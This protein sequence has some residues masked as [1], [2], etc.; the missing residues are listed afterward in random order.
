MT[1]GFSTDTLNAYFCMCVCIFCVYMCVYTTDPK[2]HFYF[3]SRSQ[4][5]MILFLTHSLWSQIPSTM[6]SPCLSPIVWW[7]RE[8][9]P[10]SEW[11]LSHC[12]DVSVTH[13]SWH[14]SRWKSDLLLVMLSLS[15]TGKKGRGSKKEMKKP[16]ILLMLWAINRITG[17]NRLNRRSFKRLQSYKDGAMSYVKPSQ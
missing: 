8:Q 10:V 15:I 9:R 5:N 3:S 4:M 7:D 1:A 16:H 2:S 12:W 6:T 13:C 17:N 11:R 14:Y